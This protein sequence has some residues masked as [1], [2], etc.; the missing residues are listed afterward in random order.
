MMEQL[1]EKFILGGRLDET[2]VAEWVRNVLAVM[3]PYVSRDM[4]FPTSSEE[5]SAFFRRILVENG[6]VFARWGWKMLKRGPV[7]G[8]KFDL[9]LTLK[10]D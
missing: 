5:R 1:Q 4:V 2:N 9:K 10:K 7:R 3:E 6:Q 8:F